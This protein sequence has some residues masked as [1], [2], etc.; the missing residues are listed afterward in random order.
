MNTYNLTDYEYG[1]LYITKKDGKIIEVLFDKEDYDKINKYTWHEN[2]SRNYHSIKAIVD[3]VTTPITKII[4]NLSFIDHID[5]N[6]FNNQKSNL[7][8]SIV[9]GVN[10]NNCNRKRTKK[11]N[12]GLPKGVRKIKNKYY[13]QIQFNKKHYNSKGFKTIEEADLWV[14]NKRI[15]LHKEFSNYD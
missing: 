2:V 1:I 14:Q 15:E 11:E 10:Y 8:S 6:P 3:G 12:N 5:N 7:R 4:M 13:G 9:N